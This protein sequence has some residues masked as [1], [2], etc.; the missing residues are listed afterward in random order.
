MKPLSSKEQNRF[1]FAVDCYLCGKPFSFNGKLSRTRS[2]DSYRIMANSLDELAFYLSNSE[3]INCK[4]FFNDDFKFKLVSR[5]GVFPYEYINSWEKLQET[6]LPPIEHFF[7]KLHNKH[8]SGE[9]YQFALTVWNTFQIK[10]IQQYAELYLKTD[11]LLL[12]DVFESFRQLC[13]KN[14]TLDS[15]CYYT[16][17]GLAFDAMLKITDVKLELLTDI[18]MV[19]FIE[20]GIR[21]GIS[22]CSN[23]YAKVTF[24]T[25]AKTNIS[26]LLKTFFDKK[27]YVLH[28]LNLQQLTA[29]VYKLVKYIDV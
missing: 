3:K 1:Y 14:Y 21:G 15:L 13:M 10:T 22:Q 24:G 17:P 11:V 20:R 5:K 28:Y 2:L 12:A 6:C 25:I 26:K 29:W 19:N 18:D 23:R 16:A 27:K 8:I 4:K 9:D 7:S